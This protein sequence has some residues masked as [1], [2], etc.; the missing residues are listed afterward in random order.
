M[1][2]GAYPQ[3]NRCEPI[4]TLRENS[5]WGARPVRTACDDSPV[6]PSHRACS[7]SSRHVFWI[8]ELVQKPTIP[9]FCCP[10][11]QTPVHTSPGTSLWFCGVLIQI[12]IRFLGTGSP[13]C[14]NL[15]P[16]STL[17][18]FTRPINSK[19]VQKHEIPPIPECGRSEFDHSIG[20]GA[21]QGPDTQL[22]HRLVPDL[23][24]KAGRLEADDYQACML[25]L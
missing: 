3:L 4:D 13:E 7:R 20:L 9:V 12:V 16:V 14:A 21:R 2:A 25:H 24:R 15:S 22:P 18:K 23:P 1:E 10:W 8:K 11:L 5:C 6:L 19:D 17:T